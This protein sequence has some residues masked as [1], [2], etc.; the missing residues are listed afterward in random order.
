MLNKVP[1]ILLFFWIIKI[2][3]TTVGE[4]AADFLSTKLELG[5]T[6]TTFVMTGLLVLALFWQFRTRRYSPRIYWLAV[7]LISVVGTLITDNLTDKYGVSLVTSTIIFAVALGLSLTV[8]YVSEKSLSI[9]TIVTTR[10]EGF[11]WSAVLFTFALG[12]AGGDLIAEKLGVGYWKSALIFAALIGLVYFAHSK[13]RLNA[14]LGFWIA[15]I[16][17][18]PLGAS[19]GDY[20]SQKRADGGLGLGTTVTSLL[21]LLTILAVVVYLTVTKRD[22]IEVEPTALDGGRPTPSDEARVLV[23]ANKAAAT[24]ALVDALRH[25][26]ASGAARFFVLVPNPDHLLFDR[27]STDVHVG[28]R[29]LADA[30]PVLGQGA[31]VEIM[32]RVAASPNAYDDIVDELNAQD[33]D[34][35]ILETPPS[36]VSHWLHVELPQRVAALGYPMTTVAASH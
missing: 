17:T 34:E 12:T 23:V 11:Y 4:T 16:L 29:L 32:G 24:P 27:V 26:A 36:H 22:L 10:R 31:G 20:L 7:V 1:E 9:H 28:E 25:R 18:R 13:L 5:L 30:L 35:I 6:G 33:Y 8:W 21:F 15:Y 2:L 19:V 3:C 14:I